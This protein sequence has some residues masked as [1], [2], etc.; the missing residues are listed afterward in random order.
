MSTHC[1]LMDG[2]ILSGIWRCPCPTADYLN[3]EVLGV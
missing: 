2:N 3:V 1:V